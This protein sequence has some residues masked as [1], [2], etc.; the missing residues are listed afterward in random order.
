MRLLSTLLKAAP[1]I[2]LVAAT[3]LSWAGEV[4]G[5]VTTDMR[6][7]GDIAVYVDA[8]PGKTFTP[9][10]QHVTMVL[11]HLEF[12][13]HALVIQHGTTVYSRTMT[14]WVTT[15]IGRA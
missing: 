14:R 7:A 3:T 5:K 9:P 6:S 13:P 1:A 2:A 15:S 4:K 10:A 11:T 12:V 8:L